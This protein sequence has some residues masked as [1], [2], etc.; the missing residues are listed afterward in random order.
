MSL[1]KIG[2]VWTSWFDNLL[3]GLQDS[4]RLGDCGEYFKGLIDFGSGVFAGHDGADAGFAFGDCGKGDT[5]SHY[6]RVE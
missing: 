2:R 4:Y 1:V 3:S 6:A 5:G